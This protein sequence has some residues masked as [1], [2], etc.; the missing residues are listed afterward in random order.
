MYVEVTDGEGSKGARGEGDGVTDVECVEG[1]DGECVEGTDVEGE[2]GT[3]KECEDGAEGISVTFSS[4]LDPEDNS[5]LYPTFMFIFT[6]GVL[7]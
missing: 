7:E 5:L 6:I 4:E 3:D 1:A 2:D